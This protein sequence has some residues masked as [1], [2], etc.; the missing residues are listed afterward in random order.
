MNHGPRIA[1]SSCLLV[2][3]SSAIG[4]AQTSPYQ[5][6]QLPVEH[7]V[8]DLLSRMTLQE[9]VA[10]L[11]SAWENRQFF[12]DPKA[13]FV[14]EKG[15]FLPQ[16]AAV[17][18]RNGLG[19]ISR[20]SENR[21]P[22]AMAEYTNTVQHWLKDNTRLGIPVIFHDECLHGHV[23][24]QGTSFPQPIALG[25]TWDPGLV[26][27]VFSATAAEVRARG[28]QQ[29]LSPVLDLGR[30]PRWG[31]T[32]E[33]YS[34]D[35]Y[36]VSRIGVAAIQGLQGQGPFID[37]RHVIATAK[38]FAVHGQP[39]GGTNPGPAYYSERSIREYFL[40]PFDA[41]VREAH[42]QTV[43]ASYNEVDGIPS[44]SNKHFLVDIL[45]QEWGFEGVLVS[46][47]F[48]ISQLA[49]FHHVVGSSQAAA[50]LALESGVDVELPYI[51]DYGTLI[52]Q[53]QQGK[54]SEARLD[55]AVA[56]VVR[57]KFLAGLFENPFVDP[58]YA[59][60]IT[61]N[62]EHRQLALKA[63]RE[64]VI[65]LKNQNS[66]LPL[67]KTKYKRIAVIGPDAADV[68]L[69]GYSGKPGRGVSV[70]QGIKD[71]VGKSSEVMYAEGC[72][73]T[74]TF[75]DWDAD[76]VVLGDP[77]LN[78]SRIQEAVAVARKADLVILALGGNEQTS[79][80]GW[81]PNHLGDRDSLDLLG[82]Q[83]DLVRAILLLSK[84]VVVFLQ[85]GRPNSINYIAEHVPAIVEGWYLG[86]EGGTAVADVLFGDYN[87][88]GKL[89]ITV[90]RSVGQLPDYYYQK[91][92]SKRGYLGTTTEPLFPF[93]WGLSYS[94]FKYAN[95]RTT[96][97][98]IGSEG[99][100]KVSVEVTNTSKVA[101]EEVIQLYIRDEVSSVTRPIKELRAFRRIPL[102][103]SETK[104]VEF[105]LGPDELSFYNRE[106]RRVVEPG[107]FKIMVGGN[108]VDLTE[109]K[110][111]VLDR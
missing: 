105:T 48:A 51:E 6:P 97:E 82:S 67:D 111:T 40:K 47:Y 9:K 70:L 13:L 91:P 17:L 60:K 85:H 38:H 7:R 39:E 24:P 81:A 8:A 3:L 43:M 73:I 68:H 57:L 35:P 86:Q 110:L 102:Q 62:P 36:L 4:L 16:Q 53:V 50:K 96:P 34:E 61:N 49:T 26:H 5:N 31:R 19:E 37:D 20:P 76:K 92:S 25:S 32:E 12:S 52:D 18:I 63:A 93:G 10:Q 2:L 66:L 98:S 75:P 72:K 100:T 11:E 29:C 41:A 33:T 94:T 99:I 79:R 71:K 54:V 42:V 74:E 27:D 103:P 108:S 106:M 87:P 109:T 65:L 80:E 22:R 44:H 30:E 55:Q 104:T 90:P 58:D 28:A 21:G 59:E 95:L 14:D 45:R 78:A 89:P 46:D 84:P 15:V 107:T 56:R 23:A 83:D 77:A 88:G 1:R 64:A 101:G 69:G